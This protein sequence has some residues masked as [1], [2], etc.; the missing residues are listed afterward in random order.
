MRYILAIHA[1]AQDRIAKAFA[2]TVTHTAFGRRGAFVLVY[3]DGSLK[4]GS[5]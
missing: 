4:I 1:R 2:P 3:E 5:S